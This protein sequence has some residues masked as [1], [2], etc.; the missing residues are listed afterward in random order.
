MFRYV[1]KS[2]GSRG[3]SLANTRGPKAMAGISAADGGLAHPQA[4][5]FGSIPACS[6][7][8]GDL[9]LGLGLLAQFL[10]LILELKAQ[11]PQVF[12][13]ELVFAGTPVLRVGHTDLQF[14]QAGAIRLHIE[15][16]C[17]IKSVAA[18]AAPT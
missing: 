18:A 16:H 4:S 10:A 6:R 13:I 7:Y 9:R 1:N 17:R 12:N 2:A 15:L 14:A 8:D 11:L 3:C 5:G